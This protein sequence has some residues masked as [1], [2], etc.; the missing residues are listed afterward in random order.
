MDTLRILSVVYGARNVYRWY[1]MFSKVDEERVGRLNTSTTDE[2]ID[3]MKK[4]VL[5]NRR[6]SVEKF[7]RT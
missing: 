4:R 1:K 6:N 7:L 3:K 2:K 5:A